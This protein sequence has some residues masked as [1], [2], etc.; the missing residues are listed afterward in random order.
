MWSRLLPMWTI[1]YDVDLDY[2]VRHL[3]L[4]RPGGEREL[5]TLVS[6]LHSQKLDRS[7]PLWEC[8]VIEGLERGRFAIYTKIH[9]A[10]ADGVTAMRLLT[11]CLSER[12]D[13]HVSPPWEYIAPQAKR[14]ASASEG[15]SFQR[16]LLTL[17]A[18]VNSLAQAARASFE[19]KMTAGAVKAPYSALNVPIS[20]QRRFSTQQFDVA[21]LKALSKVADATLNDVILALC[22]AALRRFLQESNTL[23]KAPMIAGIPVSV[24][25][26]SAVEHA[27]AVSMIFSELGTHI[28]DPRLR[29]DKIRDATAHAKACL[30]ELPKAALGPYTGLI[31]APMAA[32]IMLGLAG[33]VRPYF[34]LTVSN[35]PGPTRPLYLNGARQEAMYPV[36]NPF[37]GQALNITV[38]SYAGTLNFGFTGCRDALPHMQKLAVYAGEALPELEAAFGIENPAT[39]SQRIA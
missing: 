30:H 13:S 27:N 1:D 5:G 4:P 9:H 38:T 28:A 29:L 11:Q 19:E 22:A 10:I 16:D 34:N 39:T 17:P 25:S 2:H 32:Q 21:R 23:P 14:A 31:L 26:A 36:S 6:R 3:A 18:R 35:V 20:G 7:R 24:R 15:F 8:Y 12:A 37:N 33:R